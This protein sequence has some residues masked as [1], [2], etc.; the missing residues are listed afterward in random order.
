MLDVEGLADREEYGGAEN[1]N[2]GVNEGETAEEEVDGGS[3]P[4]DVIAQDV[5]AEQHRDHSDQHRRQVEHPLPAGGGSEARI[6]VHD[7]RR[8]NESRRFIKG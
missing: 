1:G 3:R 4:E 8:V 6:D 5:V 7:P 2:V